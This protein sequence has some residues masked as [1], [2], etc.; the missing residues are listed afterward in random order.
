MA[1]FLGDEFYGPERIKKEI[2]EKKKIAGACDH[3]GQYFYIHDEIYR[4]I[5]LKDT[6][7]NLKFCN[8]KC[9][10]SALLKYQFIKKNKHEKKILTENET[11]KVATTLSSLT[12]FRIKYPW[13]VFWSM[14]YG[15]IS[16]LEYIVKVQRKEKPDKREKKFL[17]DCRKVN[18]I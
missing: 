12:L 2:I 18:L 13:T 1:I 11:N 14:C 9:Y 8:E 6:S 10:Q 7:F 5:D 16:V 3:C 17:K 4:N 15:S